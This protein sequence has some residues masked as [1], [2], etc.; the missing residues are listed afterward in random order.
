MRARLASLEVSL[1]GGILSQ[2]ERGGDRPQMFLSKRNR[3]V[4]SKLI[5][6]GGPPPGGGN[7][8]SHWIPFRMFLCRSLVRMGWICL[9][10]R[11]AA[12]LAGGWWESKIFLSTVVPPSM[13]SLLSLFPFVFSTEL[14]R[15]EGAAVAI[16]ARKRN[17]YHLLN[18]HRNTHKKNKLT[19]NHSY[20]F[21]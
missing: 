17:I 9:E 13:R 4:I 10:L 8:L 19:L 2:P 21:S 3:R 18:L 7:S 12:K 16:K 15:G 5:E 1:T 11:L 14:A 6:F 20:L